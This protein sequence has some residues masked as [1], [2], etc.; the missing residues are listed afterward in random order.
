MSEAAAFFTRD[1]FVPRVPGQRAYP[2]GCFAPGGYWCRCYSCDR[3]FEGD[4]R[5]M[6]CEPCGI[7]SE[8]KHREYLAAMEAEYGPHASTVYATR[9]D[10]THD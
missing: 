2:V 8:A 6:Q 4:K 7:K 3:P 5:A 9:K 10:S 1:D